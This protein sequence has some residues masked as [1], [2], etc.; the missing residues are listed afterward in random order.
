MA[1]VQR[2]IRIPEENDKKLVQLSKEKPVFSINTLVSI[3]IDRGL[4]E[5][6]PTTFRGAVF[7]K[8]GG[9]LTS[10]AL[11]VRGKGNGD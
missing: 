4:D 7:Q 6:D 9:N 11:K 2:L 8:L 10:M 5:L 3:F 1:W